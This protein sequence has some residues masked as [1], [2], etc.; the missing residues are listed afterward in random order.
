MAQEMTEIAPIEIKDETGKIILQGQMQNCERE[1]KQ[2]EEKLV[3]AQKD[4]DNYKTQADLAAQVR[5]LQKAGF[6]KLDA[7]LVWEFE[8]QPEYWELQDK[9]LAYKHREEEARDVGQLTRFEAVKKSVE[10]SLEREQQKLATYQE[11][12]K[13]FQ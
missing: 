6:R 8:K 10:E 5:A 1:I 12:L 3:E 4:I 7:H 13:E 11:Q 9:L 2:F